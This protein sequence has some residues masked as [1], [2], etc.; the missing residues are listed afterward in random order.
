MTAPTA[1]DR[2]LGLAR[3][4][5]VAFL[6]EAMFASA[7]L[8]IIAPYGFVFVLSGLACVVGLALVL[9]G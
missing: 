9:G 1:R 8:A 6:I 5:L 4:L 2:G 7:V 3:G